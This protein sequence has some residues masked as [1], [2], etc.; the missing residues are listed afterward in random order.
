MQPSATVFIPILK[1]ECSPGY[2][3]QKEQA[4]NLFFFINLK[5]TEKVQNETNR[6]SSL[7]VKSLD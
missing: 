5:I 7:Y 4:M 3:L 2:N 6:D 1:V